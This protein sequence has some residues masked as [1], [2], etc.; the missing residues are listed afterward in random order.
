MS[1]RRAPGDSA[2]GSASLTLG[3]VMLIVAGILLLPLMVLL[4]RDQ[5]PYLTQL[6][7][8]GQPFG[9]DAFNF[10]TAVRLCWEGQCAAAYDLSAF[11]AHQTQVLGEATQA[12]N[13]FLYPPSALVLLYPL[14]GLPYPLALACWSA[15][16]FA[17][18][19]VAVAAPRF[20]RLTV[21][22]A[23]MAPMAW[24]GLAM[25]QT[26][27][28]SAALLIGGLRLSGR[29]PLLAGVL[30]GLLSFKPFLGVLIPLLLLYRRQWRTFVSAALTTMLLAALPVLLWGWQVWA[31]WL[32][33]AVPLQRLVLHHGAGIGVWMI[34][35]AFN[36]ARL[37][38]WDLAVAYALH[39]LVGVAALALFARYLRRA[40]PAQ[41]VGSADL[42]VLVLVTSLLSPYIHNYDLVALEGA[43]LVWLS[44]GAVRRLRSNRLAICLTLLWS[45]GLLSFA[46]NARGVPIAPL[47]ALLALALL[48]HALGRAPSA[49]EANGAVGRDGH[50]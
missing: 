35:S 12:L 28:L 18:F 15:L 32:E 48:V 27:L 49:G 45:L 25:G 20:D 24:L 36:S 11:T 44:S 23:L 33:H 37:L 42:L 47:L 4:A 5:S 34:P 6:L 8:R 29:Q 39:G 41:G 21:G 38:G 50:A 40:A 1:R 19:F 7:D 3:A 2:G 10:W 30:I 13:C 17:A 14:G 43:M 16:G 46:F 31:A 26:G 22:L 9:R